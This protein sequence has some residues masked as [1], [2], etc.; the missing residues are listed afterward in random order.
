MK[1]LLLILMLLNSSITHAQVQPITEQEQIDQMSVDNSIYALVNR[2]D[3]DCRI[4]INPKRKIPD[5]EN[6][7]LM[8]D[9]PAD[10]STEYDR[11][12]VLLSQG[13]SCVAGTFRSKEEACSSISIPSCNLPALA[14]LESELPKYKAERQAQLDLSNKRKDFIARFRVVQG[15]WNSIMVDY[16]NAHPEITTTDLPSAERIIM[17][18][19]NDSLLESMESMAMAVKAQDDAAKAAEE[20][21]KA[22]VEELKA[23]PTLTLAELTELIKKM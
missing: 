12:A 6:A 23:K 10:L 8:I 5:P 19:L 18:S 15:Y 11:T 14:D 16:M 3:Q 20:A 7:D 21:R 13:W 2:L 9:D 1:Y 4:K 22:R 17:S